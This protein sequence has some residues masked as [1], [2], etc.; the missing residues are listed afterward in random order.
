M[1]MSVEQ[2]ERQKKEGRF[3]ILAVDDAQALLVPGADCY[4]EDWCYLLVEFK[5]NQPV[6]IL[7][8]DGG[9]P[10]DQSLVRDWQWVAY[11]LNGLATK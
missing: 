5:D 4:D 1:G 8:S 6:R 11:E 9:A 3:R 7:G 2:Y 10:E